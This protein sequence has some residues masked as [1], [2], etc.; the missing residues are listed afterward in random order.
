M[1]TLRTLLAIPLAVVLCGLG[2]PA[3]PAEPDRTGLKDAQATELA[4]LVTDTGAPAA[5]LLTADGHHSRFGTAGSGLGRDDRFRAGSVT[6]SFVATVVLQLAAE[7]RLRLDDTVEQHLPGLIR[8]HGN[9]GRHLT[10]RS[11]LSHTSGL[12]PYTADSTAPVPLTPSQAVHTAL[13]HSP[14]PLGAYAYSNT[15]YV[16]LGMV[17]QQVTGHPYADEAERRI[18]TPLRLTGTSFPGA[19]TTLPTPHSRAYSPDGQDVTA[20]DPRPAGAAGEL[21]STLADLSRFYA[22]LLGGALLPAPQ[23]RELLDT[24]AT[25]GVYGLG[26]YPRRLSC[27]LTVWGHNGHISGSVVRAA[28]TADGRRTAVFRINTDLSISPSLELSLLDAEFCPAAT[29]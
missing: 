10:L 12:F 21:I 9:D 6:K 4:R 25:H 26:V 18:I 19:R 29:P 24:A 1:P 17:V 22:A 7:G 23:R 3:L 28:A 8:G 16:V 15:N 14:G 13:T 2:T 11:L 5:A 27:G 20:L